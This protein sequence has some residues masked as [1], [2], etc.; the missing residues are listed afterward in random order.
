MDEGQFHQQCGRVAAHA[1]MANLRVAAMIEFDRYCR[2]GVVLAHPLSDKVWE[3]AIAH[4]FVASPCGQR[5]TTIE[6][7]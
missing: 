5:R 2:P 3:F 6:V 7:P 1:H 4:G